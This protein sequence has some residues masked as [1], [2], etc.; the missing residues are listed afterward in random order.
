MRPILLLLALLIHQLLLSQKQYSATTLPEAIQ[1][2][3]TSGR[4]VFVQ[5]ESADCGQCN[6]VADKGIQHPDV[7]AELAKRFIYLRI[8]P[9]HVDRNTVS[10]T[11]NFSTEKSF[12]ILFL[13]QDGSLIHTK[14]GS[15]SLAKTYTQQMQAAYDKAGE[16]LGITELE[17]E[18]KKGNRSF[19]FLALLL[20]KRNSLGLPTDALLEEYIA[21]L[22]PDSLAS[23]GTLVFIAQMAPLLDSKPD[24]ALRSNRELFNKAWYSIPLHKRI[25][26]NNRIIYKSMQQAITQKNESFAFRTASFARATYN[27]N[28]EAGAKAFDKNMLRYYEE[29]NDSTQYFKKSIAYYE[30]FFMSVAPDSIR[31]VD[32]VNKRQLLSRSTKRDTVRRGDTLQISTT[33]A[34]RPIAQNF[35]SELNEG[36]WNFFL[37]TTNPYLLRIAAEWS[38]RSLE[39]FETPESLDTYAKLL[40][41]LE[42]KSEAQKLMEKAIAMLQK[43]GFSAQAFVSSL[44]KMKKNQTVR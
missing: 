1:Q 12:G 17:K 18:Y 22:P 6:E 41:Q 25:A 32:S 5:F 7:Q 38:K 2:A 19:G 24:K 20:T 43:R 23:A 35:S 28:Y 14:H 34:Y 33:I 37:K 15:T 3:G 26:Y 40:Y 31:R 16:I 21:S 30:R 9:S 29:I 36:A 42:R 13:N 4:L 27:S 11:Y 8:S 39:F 44:E 10:S